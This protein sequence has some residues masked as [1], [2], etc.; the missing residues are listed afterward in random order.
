MAKRKKAKRAADP[1]AVRSVALRREHAAEVLRRRAQ[2]NR[3]RGV[4]HIARAK[5]LGAS[6]AALRAKSV[7]LAAASGGTIVAE[8][9]SWCVRP[10]RVSKRLGPS[11][12]GRS[13]DRKLPLL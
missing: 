4:A 1:L 11:S 6:P 13:M 10:R 3:A 12:S 9:D 7:T 5:A 8:G 2:T